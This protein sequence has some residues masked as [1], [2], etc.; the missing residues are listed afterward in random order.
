MSGSFLHH[1]DLSYTNLTNVDL[2]NADLYECDILNVCEYNG[3]KCEDTNFRESQLNDKEFVKYLK[4]NG[5]VNV[6]EP[7]DW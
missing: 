4:N 6:P 1:C 3:L 2:S 5:A 7:R